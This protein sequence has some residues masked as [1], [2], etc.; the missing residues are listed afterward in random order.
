M[1]VVGREHVH[2]ERS[3]ETPNIPTD[4][5]LLRFNVLFAY[6][7]DAVSGGKGMLQFKIDPS[8]NQTINNRLH[9]TFLSLKCFDNETLRV[10][11]PRTVAY[12]HALIIDSIAIVFEASINSRAHEHEGA[13]VDVYSEMNSD[14]FTSQLQATLRAYYEDIKGAQGASGCPKPKVVKRKFE[15]QEDA[16]LAQKAAPARAA[17][18]DANDTEDN[19]TPVTPPDGG[20]GAAAE[21]APCA[22]PSPAGVPARRP[23]AA[24]AAG[25]KSGKS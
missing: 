12:I 25:R 2:A 19:A 20:P 14:S 5:V 21:E 15:D 4:H 8:R 16:G 10:I 9:E 17:D 7:F 24:A 18:T 13:M 23:A 3:F 22:V 11:N 1:S 6:V